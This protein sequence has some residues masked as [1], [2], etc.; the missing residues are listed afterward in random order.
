MPRLSPASHVTSPCF[1]HQEDNGLRR[2]EAGRREGEWAG[3][4]RMGEAAC[5]AQPR[6]RAVAGDRAP[7]Q[8]SCYRAAVVELFQKMC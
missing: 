7:T 5:R 3:C 4:L 1:V 8:Q 6:D 2:E